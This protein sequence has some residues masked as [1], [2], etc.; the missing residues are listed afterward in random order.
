MPE[1][2][3]LSSR[4]S[5]QHYDQAQEYLK[6]GDWASYGRELDAVKTVLEQLAELSGGE[7]R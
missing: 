7:G 6:A 2:Q 5:Q 4:I 3:L 1:F